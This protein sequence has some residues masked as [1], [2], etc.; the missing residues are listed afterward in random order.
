MV[1]SSSSGAATEQ[2]SDVLLLEAGTGPVFVLS[3]SPRHLH[4]H[5]QEEHL[6]GLEGGVL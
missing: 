4:W 6:L 1:K 2:D 5:W 3:Y